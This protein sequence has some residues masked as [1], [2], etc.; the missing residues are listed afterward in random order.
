MI[1][2]GDS[3]HDMIWDMDMISMYEYSR[4]VCMICMYTDHSAS[5]IV[6]TYQIDYGRINICSQ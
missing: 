3:G 2:S 5:I 6:S 4:Y 1:Y